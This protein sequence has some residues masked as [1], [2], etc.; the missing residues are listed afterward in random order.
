[1]MNDMN[2]STKHYMRNLIWM[3]LIILR[4]EVLKAK[5]E[6]KVDVLVAK[7]VAKEVSLN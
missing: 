7:K 4:V 1:M 6:D 2:L 5:N 3:E